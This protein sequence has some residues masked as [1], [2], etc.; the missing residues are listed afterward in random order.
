MFGWLRTWRDAFVLYSVMEM[1]KQIT[2]TGV[3]SDIRQVTIRFP[4][5]TLAKLDRLAAQAIQTKSQYLTK[6]LQQV[7]DVEVVD[8]QPESLTPLQERLCSWF[9]RRITTKWTLK[10]QRAYRQN[11]HLTPVEDVEIMEFYYT[12]KIPQETDYRRR[13]IATLLNNWPG[14]LDRARNFMAAIKKKR[15]NQG[16]GWISSTYVSVPNGRN[17]TPDEVKAGVAELRSKMGLPLVE[18]PSVVRDDAPDDLE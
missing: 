5:A 12:A 1:V 18:N 7:D 6:L 14:E 9:D 13:D 4:A 15:T 17:L 8:A 10:E 2:T 11:A 3:S 16:Q